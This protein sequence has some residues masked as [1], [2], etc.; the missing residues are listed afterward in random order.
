M[1]R[2]ALILHINYYEQGQS[3]EKACQ[4]AVK[5]GFDGIEFRRKRSGKEE[6]QETYLDEIESAVAKSGLKQVIFGSPGPNLMTSDA[7]VREAELEA[8]LD[9]YANARKRF[10][11]TISNTFSGPL[12]NPDPAIPYSQ[13]D[14]QG[15]FVATPE[16]WEQA[17][18][19]FKQLGKL[20]E[21]I[22]LQLAFETHMGYLHD[23]PEAAKKLVDAIGSPNVG[24]ALDSANIALIPGQPGLTE[25]VEI[26]G[27]RIF[28]LHLKNIVQYP[29]GGFSCTALGS[30]ALN[31][32]ELLSALQARGFN[33]PIGIEAPRPGDRE[34]FAR[35]DIA[36]LQAVLDDLEWN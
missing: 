12:L 8:A 3:L 26:L 17:T 29:G 31:N 24:V 10:G 14:K 11:T 4:D 21:E 22:G 36:Y 7:S 30:G 9:F 23:V 32:R 35:E 15:S 19:G 33:G 20:A 18:E 34:W 28:Y 13:Y 1:A 27:D 25:Q 16:Q 2:P 6:T 5:L